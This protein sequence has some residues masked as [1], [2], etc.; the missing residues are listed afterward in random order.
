M[1]TIITDQ[2]SG[3]SKRSRQRDQDELTPKIRP[4]RGA[5]R[6]GG[7]VA[8]S[9][10]CPRTLPDHLVRLF[11]LAPFGVGRGIKFTQRVTFPPDY[12]DGA[13]RWTN[14]RNRTC[15]AQQ[16]DRSQ[17]RNPWHGTHKRPPQLKSSVCSSTARFRSRNA[18]RGLC[19]NSGSGFDGRRDFGSVLPDRSSMLQNGRLRMNAKFCSNC[20]CGKQKP[21][22]YD[23]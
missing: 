12:G 13:R 5:A 7:I 19:E 6:A 20:S 8:L 9:A 17:A 14:L 23:N 22:Q 2:H 18:Q 21:M 1:V 10:V 3:K 11:F 4:G 16:D 15:A